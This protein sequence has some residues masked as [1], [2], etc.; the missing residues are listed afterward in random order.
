MNTTWAA[1]CDVACNCVYV[2]GHSPLH[3]FDFLLCSVSALL[4]RR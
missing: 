3:L 1:C 2:P 4:I